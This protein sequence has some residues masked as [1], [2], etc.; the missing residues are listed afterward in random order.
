[1]TITPKPKLR[2]LGLYTNDM[3][4]ML[5]FYTDVMGLTVTD[6]G[7]FGDPPS[8]IIFMSSDPG[9]HHEFVLIDAPGGQDAS[10]FAQQ[11]SFLLGSLDEQRVL[12][13][14]VIAAGRD[15][16]RM[17]THGNAWSFYFNDPEGNRI[18]IYVHTPWHVP[19]PHA[20]P[21]DLTLPNDEIMAMTEAH[22]REDAGFMAADE[23]EKMMAAEMGGGA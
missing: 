9:E 19:Q 18:E 4:T 3:D 5:A 11:I 10:A 21:F 15:V 20:H 6:R 2:H 13:E 22:C 7:T 12:Y 17:I 1:M 23:R 16:N 8:R 14:R